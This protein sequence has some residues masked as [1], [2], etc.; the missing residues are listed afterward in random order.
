VALVY[1]YELVESANKGL[2]L[3]QRIE[4]KTG[5]VVPL[6]EATWEEIQ[7]LSDCIRCKLKARQAVLAPLPKARF[8]PRTNSEPASAA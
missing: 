2:W 5:T 3:L 8:L 6:L 7:D 1:R 4:R